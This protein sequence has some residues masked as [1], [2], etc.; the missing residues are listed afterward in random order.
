MTDKNS[1]TYNGIT[2]DFTNFKHPGEGICGAYLSDYINKDATE[3]IEHTD[4][5]LEKAKLEGE[6]EGLKC[7]SNFSKNL[8]FNEKNE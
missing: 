7:I 5:I 1:I 8:D 4:E 6:C 2:Y 3:E